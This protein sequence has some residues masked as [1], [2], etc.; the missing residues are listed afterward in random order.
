[1]TLTIPRDTI[2]S[3][4]LLVEGKSG[5]NFFEALLRHLGLRISTRNFG[6]VDELRPFLMAFAQQPEFEA[7]PS[8]GVVRDAEEGEAASARQSVRDAIERVATSLG[9]R[10]AVV[11]RRTSILIL[12]DDRVAGSLETLLWRTVPADRKRRCVD[13]F[14]ECVGRTEPGVR[15]DKARVQSWLALKPRPGVSVGVAAQ[16]GYWNLDHP[17]LHHVRSFLSRLARQRDV[18]PGSASHA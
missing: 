10:R 13:D 7:V 1:M 5:V 6:G 4:A 9:G 17:E 8:L 11:L 2:G 12:P 18:A 14:M 3:P 15:D 16:K